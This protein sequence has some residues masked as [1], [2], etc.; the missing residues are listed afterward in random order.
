M[1]SFKV[2]KEYQDFVSSPDMIKNNLLQPNNDE[3]CIKYDIYTNNL[4][5]PNLFTDIQ[6]F[7]KE[8]SKG[9][10]WFIDKFKLYLINPGHFHGEVIFGDSI[11]DEWY[12][13][14]ILFH[15]SLKFPHLNITTQD[16]DGEF[17]LIETAD[18]LPDWLEPHTTNNRIWIKSGL[19]KIIVNDNSD[20]GDNE[21]DLHDA[22][23]LLNNSSNDVD[24]ENT[25]CNEIQVCLQKRISCLLYTSP[26][27]RDLSTSRMP[28][29]A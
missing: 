26:S 24:D 2:P 6:D 22:L 18:Y 8:L 11:D 25:A 21:L 5:C 4:E 7:I 29:S 20:R 13:V 16:N 23:F 14:Y 27:P 17:L 1:E 28:S 19:L 10:I 12:V 3:N 9:Y 15:L